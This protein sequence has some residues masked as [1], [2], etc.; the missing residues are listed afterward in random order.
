MFPTSCFYF[1][2]V[3]GVEN[4]ITC[5]LMGL[6]ESERPCPKAI[7]L[8]S[9]FCKSLSGTA[10]PLQR[11]KHLLDETWKC[12]TNLNL[13]NPS[14]HSCASSHVLVFHRSTGNLF[15]LLKPCHFV[16]GLFW[17]AMDSFACLFDI[18]YYSESTAM[19]TNSTIFDSGQDPEN[20]K[21]PC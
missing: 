15:L 6:K 16:T 19:L 9:I 10:G 3:Q 11:R 17:D 4:F 1:T 13:P 20:Y 21:Q 8:S 5:V 12:S 7:F 2:T 14:L 18:I